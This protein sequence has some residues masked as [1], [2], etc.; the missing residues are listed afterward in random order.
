MSTLLVHR[1]SATSDT[2]RYGTHR[3]GKAVG[4]GYEGKHFLG[5]VSE[6]VRALALSGVL[7][8]QMQV[9]VAREL[10]LT[11]KGKFEAKPGN[12]AKTV[13]GKT[14]LKRVG[15]RGIRPVNAR[16][17]VLATEIR[18]QVVRNI[19]NSDKGSESWSSNTQSSLLKGFSVTLRPY[20]TG[21][22]LS[23]Q[24]KQGAAYAK[25]WAQELGL[26]SG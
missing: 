9:L 1:I 10:A 8:T 5:S 11:V 23:A 13:F 19:A 16:M 20:G 18:Q 24:L 25:T 12:I 22:V 7:T 6:S 2:V 4:P 26:N 15:I 17:A 3:M 21:I 14:G